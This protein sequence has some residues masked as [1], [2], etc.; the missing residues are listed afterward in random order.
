MSGYLRER[1]KGR[2][3]LQ[4]YVGKDPVSGK[5]RYVTQTF[6]GSR[7]DAK[8]ALRRLVD[9]AHR[10]EASDGLTM[11][12]AQF[13]EKWLEWKSERVRPTT[14]R[15]YKELTRLY[16]IP[17]LGG[18]KLHRVRPLVIEDAY[19]RASSLG[20]SAATVHHLHRTLHAAFEQAVRWQ[21]MDRNPAHSV[22]PPR[23]EKKRREPV[24]PQQ[25]P[26][27]IGVV[28]GTSLELPTLL[29]IGCGLR[30]GEA[31]GVR[32]QDVGWEKSTL[33]VTQIL[34]VDMSFGS[35]KSHRSERTM[36]IPGF[37]IDALRRHRK[38]QNERRLQLGDAWSELGLIND[39]GDGR[40]LRPDAVSKGF[41]R[42]MRSNGV[43]LTFH[44][45]R[46]GH[47]DLMLASGGD[48]KTTSHRMGHS[49]ISLTGD[50]YTHVASTHDR[51]AAERFDSYL[52]P[53]LSESG[54][55]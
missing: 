18:L 7:S 42:L 46:H 14:L 16:A 47:A 50:V 51:L 36:T 23:R 2:W 12:V 34:H 20:L 32:W 15:R 39:R 26:H 40:P 52:S 19:A 27:V 9:A 35:P 24:T 54:G 33:R 6:R 10:A 29:G 53:Y 41:A 1:S 4:A 55:A 25:L 21:L 13:L 8:A 28:R 11:T 22:T 3:Q 30:L 38:H 31:L 48:L 44:G 49:S 43:E 37:C 45:L 17:V 5:K